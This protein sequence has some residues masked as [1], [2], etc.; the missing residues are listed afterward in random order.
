[1][2]RQIIGRTLLFLIGYTYDESIIT[3][4]K[5]QRIVAIIIHT[6]KMDAIIACI[7][8]MIMPSQYSYTTG[9]SSKYMD[10][11][12]FGPILSAF[13]GIRIPKFDGVKYNTVDYI[14]KYL[15]E[16]PTR[17]FIIAPEGKIMPSNW[18]SGFYHVANAIRCPIVVVGIDYY[19]HQIIMDPEYFSPTGDYDADIPEIQHNFIHSGIHP[20][21]PEC[22]NPLIRNVDRLVTS[23]PI[24]V[25]LAWVFIIGFN[26]IHRDM[27][28]SWYI[29]YFATFYT[30]RYNITNP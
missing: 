30:S 11:W 23:I 3:R 22:S 13:G 19:N 2:L 6:S 25:V 18:K 21:Y 8:N 4:A 15:K 16:N 5:K 7:F 9:I 10:N 29:A 24:D 20:L 14:V 1:M 12:L 26:I 28:F 17:S 27:S